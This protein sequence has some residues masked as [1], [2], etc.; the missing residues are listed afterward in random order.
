[1]DVKNIQ[2]PSTIKDTNTRRFITYLISLII[3]LDERLKK[4]EP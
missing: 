1:M 4:L 3:E 2:I